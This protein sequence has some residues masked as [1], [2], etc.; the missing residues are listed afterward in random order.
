MQNFSRTK[1]ALALGLSSSLLAAC[2]GGG[3]S[4]T[5]STPTPTSSATVITAANYTAVAAS[6]WGTSDLFLG[7]NDGLF[8]GTSSGGGA[9]SVSVAEQVVSLNNQANRLAS[10]LNSVDQS[11]TQSCRNGGTLAAQATLAVARNLSLGGKFDFTATNCTVD[12]SNLNGQL[13]LQVFKSNSIDL[14]LNF[15]NLSMLDAGEKL[16]LDGD[17]KLNYQGGKTSA[18]GSRL[19]VVYTRAGK[20]IYDHT[21]TNF[22]YSYGALNS[23]GLL[24][25]AALTG[26]SASLGA[27]NLQVQTTQAFS[28]SGNFGN[29]PQLGSM[30][31]TGK[32]ASVKL[33]ALGGN[34]VKVE[35]SEKGDGTITL[36]QTMTY[37]QLKSLQ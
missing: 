22:S 8:T 26:N 16:L 37:D 3:S 28:H 23:E 34:A 29:Y 32:G 5:P 24:L 30:L 36:S 1:L 2:G 14:G 33:T 12:T 4:S 21:L 6:A 11:L 31:V 27:L 9:H 18:S 15:T 17:L 7:R 13:S 25:N 10:N 19:H 35:F 20:Q